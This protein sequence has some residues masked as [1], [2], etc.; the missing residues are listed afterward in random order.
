ME[1]EPE[2]LA[3]RARLPDQVE[4]AAF[5]ALTH[6]YP[7]QAQLWLDRAAEGR[8]ARVQPLLAEQPGDY[9]VVEL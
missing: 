4:Q 7:V 5:L 6:E 2:G 9:L 8:E 3:D 1:V